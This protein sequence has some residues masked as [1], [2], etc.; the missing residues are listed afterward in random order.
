MKKI[1]IMILTFGLMLGLIGCGSDV[2]DFNVEDEFTSDG[3]LIINLFGHEMDDLQSPSTETKKILDIIENK[4]N[5]KLKVTTTTFTSSPTLLNQ[6]IGGGDVPDLFIHFKKEPSYSSWI[7]GKIMMDFEPYLDKYAN[8]KN[9]FSALGSEKEVK[10]LLK[11]GYNSYPIIIHNEFESGE[12]FTELGMY[13]RRDW[14]QSL[15]NKNYIAQSGKAIKDPEDPTFNYLDFYDLLEGY[16]YGD[17][18]NN[19]LDDTY[20]Y[21]L[22]K[23]EGVFWWNPILNMFGVSPSGWYQDQSGKW[24]PEA[25][26]DKMYEA[27]KFMSK[28]YD[29]KLI[30]QDYNTTTTFE[31]AKNNYINGNAGMVV[32]NVTGTMGSGIVDMMKG[33][34]G[35]VADSK[36][37][38]DVVRGMPVVTGVDGTKRVIGATN[39]YAYMAINNDIT[40]NKKQTILSLLDWILSEEGDN[41]LTWGIED[42]H[43]VV[44][45]DGSFKSI[46]SLNESGFQRQLYDN[47]IAPGVYRLKGLVSWDTQFTSDPRPYPEVVDQLMSAWDSSHMFVDELFFISV[48]SEFSALSSELDDKIAITFKSI[49]SR[50]NGSDAEKAAKRDEIW[51]DFIRFYN[52]KGNKYI[53]MMNE[54]AK[55]LAK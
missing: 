47:L 12:L 45:E 1:I 32:S 46:L 13:Y 18:D 36:E 22:H 44:E 30:N 43:Y 29:N 6:L 26:S 52:L 53:A 23:D 17:P 31:G 20:G 4:F 19:G 27:L 3:K 15:V 42:D 37:M 24:L 51:Q 7:H 49:V 5:I 55:E 33:Y 9:A 28:L 2:I 16:T 39:S 21:S 38:L 48:D 34:L 25:T 54:K 10:M 14:Y 11:G 40:E 35:K 50:M 41:L 8:L